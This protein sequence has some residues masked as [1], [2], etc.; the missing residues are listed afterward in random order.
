MENLHPT[1]FPTLPSQPKCKN[2]TNPISSPYFTTPKHT[3]P[4]QL[5]KWLMPLFFDAGLN[6]VSLYRTI[7]LT[8]TGSVV[9]VIMHAG[10]SMECSKEMGSLGTP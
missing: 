4:Y 10:Y 8:S 6:P 7:Y 9:Q 1:P 3:D 5:P 2:P